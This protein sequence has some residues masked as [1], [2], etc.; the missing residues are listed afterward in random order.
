MADDVVKTITIRGKKDGV[1]ET[2]ASLNKLADAQRTVATVSD[3]TSKSALSVEAAYARQTL[4]IDEA[5]KMAHKIATETKLAKSAF[6]QGVIS[7]EAYRDRVSDI[8][9]KYTETAAASDVFG[10]AIDILQ[11]KLLGMGGSGGSA[12][13]LVA[14]FAGAGGLAVAFIAAGA[15]AGYFFDQYFPKAKTAEELLAEQ[16]RLIEAIRKGYDDAGGAARVYYDSLI[17]FQARQNRTESQTKLVEGT[18]SALF[19]SPF[20][21]S[22]RPMTLNLGTGAPE[23]LDRFKDFDGPLLKLFEQFERGNP[24]LITFNKEIAAMGLA[25]PA[26]APLVAELLKLTEATAKLHPD[27]VAEMRRELD[28]TAQSNAGKA[29]QS[30]YNALVNLAPEENASI[31]RQQKLTDAFI[32]R[33]KAWMELQKSGVLREADPATA[34]A[35]WN[36]IEALY[37]TAIAKLNTDLPKAADRYQTLTQQI[38]D[39]IE[40]MELQSASNGRTT[41]EVTKLKTAHDLLRAAMRAGREDT[42]ALRAEIDKTADSYAR[43]MTEVS[44]A[45]LVGD[46][47]FERD[48]LGRD[49]TDATVASRLRGAGLPVDLDSTLASYLRLNEQQK[50]AKDLTVEFGSSLAR[51]LAK[52]VK[53]IDA[54]TSALGRLQDKLIDIVMNKAISSAFNSLLPSVGGGDIYAA[55]APGAITPAINGGIGHAHTGGIVGVSSLAN[56]YV[57]PAYFDNAPRFHGGGMIG[58]D[59]VPIIAR[60]GEG[61]FTREQMAAM[62]G[63]GGT[64]VN[65]QVN[66]SAGAEVDVQQ[67]NNSS[68]GVDLVVMVNKAVK[69]EMGRG[70]YDATMGAN[71]GARR[72]PKTFA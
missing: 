22:G 64:V 50:L 6:D 61:V 66:N 25:T 56:K 44:R 69:G 7:V 53:P 41:E 24:D 60:K 48:Q 43:M 47:R 31:I 37:Q 20:D 10:K 65:V 49:T 15:A 40:E 9:N 70:G 14:K 27:K 11:G 63:G 17:E 34:A 3:T 1:D 21:R 68:G 59:E 16:G 55:G 72:R 52:G 19:G 13:G 4:R 12:A 45:K 46:V 62:G 33:G 39:N 38:K 2:T 35:E 23:V 57:H 28:L 18:R 71:F 51:D 30:A 29:Y 42:P 54:L 67:Q 5:A 26:L 36:K 58:S 8:K 32:N